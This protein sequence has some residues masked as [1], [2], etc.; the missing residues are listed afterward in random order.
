MPGQVEGIVN[1]QPKLDQSP[2][3]DIV[4]MSLWSTQTVNNA[5]ESTFN[6]SIFE[7][8]NN[9]RKICKKFAD[10]ALENG[11][12]PPEFYISILLIPDWKI[13]NNSYDH[14]Q[15]NKTKDQFFE[16]VNG[17][18]R[19]LI[20]ELKAEGISLRIEDFYKDAQLNED[21]KKFMHQQESNGSNADIIKTKAILN[22]PNRRHLQMD[23]NTI[24]KDYRSFYNQTFGAP[25]DEQRDAAN[26]NHY[27]PAHVSANNKI[28]YISPQGIIAPA[29]KEE[30]YEFIK[31]NCSNKE[32]KAKG[33]NAVYEYGFAPALNKVGLTYANLEVAKHKFYYPADMS[34]PEY[35]I[36]RDVVT[37]INMSWA[38]NAGVSLTIDAIKKLPPLSYKDA[39]YDTAAFNYL[40]KKYTGHLPRCIKGKENPKEY[41][42]NFLEISD[43]STDMTVLKQFYIEVFSNDSEKLKVALAKVLPKEKLQEALKD[44][45]TIENLQATLAKAFP[46]TTKGNI[47]T[48]ALFGRSVK[49]LHSN[50]QN[51]DTTIRLDSV[52]SLKERLVLADGEMIHNLN[53]RERG[54]LAEKLA[55]KA[56]YYMQENHLDLPL[57]QVIKMVDFAFAIE[58]GVNVQKSISKMKI[59]PPA[60]QELLL[61]EASWI[62]ENSNDIAG[63]FNFLPN[64]KVTLKYIEQAGAKAE[65][66]AHKRATPVI[67]VAKNVSP[68]IKERVEHFESSKENQDNKKPKNSLK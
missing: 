9:I 57:A 62:V 34:K 63:H 60:L 32:H 38:A 29:L 33:T 45:E 51:I 22:N 55:E 47:L 44:P 30:Y 43:I 37:A 26:A 49:Q 59:L 14:P 67:N 25:N 28:V 13:A 8:K 27:A 17:E 46:D 35:R 58:D 41:Y 68:G 48:K 18:F 65:A 4:S 12:S 54:F 20:Q 11:Q 66:N 53:R 24:I 21:E 6:K 61:K 7:Q 36:T 19:A 52:N 3:T 1:N 16:M 10:V 56:N 23:T 31:N 5:G 50:P 2:P 42:K 40:I 39:D 15:Y 64:R